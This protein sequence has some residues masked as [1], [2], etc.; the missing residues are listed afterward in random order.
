[1]ADYVLFNA[2]AA[3]VGGVAPGA[4]AKVTPASDAALAALLATDGVAVISDGCNGTL[5]NALA[6]MLSDVRVS[7]TAV[8]D[9]MV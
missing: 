8:P 5:K 7:G 4:A 3:A 6:E 1:M 2:S 9:R